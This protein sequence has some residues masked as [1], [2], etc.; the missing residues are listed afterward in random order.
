MELERNNENAT[1]DR[2]EQVMKTLVYTLAVF[3]TLVLTTQSG[4]GAQDLPFRS[5]A[6]A[7]A[8]AVGLTGETISK[9]E[10]LPGRGRD[11][12]MAE[13]SA[14]FAPG[15]NLT[16][17]TNAVSTEGSS[18]MTG[19]GWIIEVRGT[20]ESVRFL[21]AG[22]ID[23]PANRPC[24]RG[25]GLT[26]DALEAAAL[27][28]IKK[29]LASLV[30]LGPGETLQGWQ[31]S[32]L[33]DSVTDDSGVLTEKVVASRILFT[34]AIDGVPV[35]GPGNKVSVTFANDGALVGFD[36]DWP[37][38]ARKKGNLRIT[39]FSFTRNEADQRQGL[40][41]GQQ[42]AT[43]EVFECGYYDPGVAGLSEGNSLQ[44]ACV[45]IAEYGPNEPKQMVVIP[46]EE[47]D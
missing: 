33:I 44:P 31:V 19:E 32:R 17:R 39:P 26:E 11:I 43:E 34:R 40:A 6:A 25:E 28:V 3:S 47:K 8:K 38:L 10:R 22:Y 21:N 30:K 42:G 13:V 35:L 7:K 36:L 14:R 46:C 20:G 12:V 15:G 41:W 5:T 24:S 29:E 4:A 45:S 27:T 18:I 9:I 37:K 16:V 23:S 2:G 1:L